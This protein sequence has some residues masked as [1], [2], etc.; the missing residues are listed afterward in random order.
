MIS[1]V[2]YIYLTV[3]VQNVARP[4][5]LETNKEK[6]R[7][8]VVASRQRVFTA[9]QVGTLF[10]MHKADWGITRSTPPSRFLEF[11]VEQGLIEKRELRP[12]NSEYKPFTRYL[13]EDAS[14]FEVRDVDPGLAVPGPDPQFSQLHALG[15]FE[16][17]PLERR[18]LHYVQQE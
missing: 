6:I 18:V 17:R 9:T 11:I 5:S 7:E 12:E 8:G 1:T 15:A 4:S 3:E 13:L 14:G 16:Q 10:D 2:R